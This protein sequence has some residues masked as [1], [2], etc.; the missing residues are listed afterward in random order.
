MELALVRVI[1]LSTLPSG[2]HLAPGFI[3]ALWLR[4]D[5]WKNTRSTKFTWAL[6]GYGLRSIDADFL[7][8]QDQDLAASCGRS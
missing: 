1:T 3:H 4:S 7:D 2:I 5:A 6:A 8:K